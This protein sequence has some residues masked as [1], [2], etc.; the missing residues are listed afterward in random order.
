M[1]TE[2][3]VSEYQLLDSGTCHGSAATPKP[4]SL[5]TKLWT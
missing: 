4:K 5:T 3:A 1:A 2:S